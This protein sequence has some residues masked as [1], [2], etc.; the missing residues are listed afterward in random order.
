MAASQSPAARYFSPDGDAPLVAFNAGVEIG[1]IAVAMVIVPLFWKL[2]ARPAP[3]L[4]L[5]SAWSLLVVVAGSYW[6]VERI[7]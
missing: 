3:R 2:H 7:V 5:A 4:P 6:L 1:Q